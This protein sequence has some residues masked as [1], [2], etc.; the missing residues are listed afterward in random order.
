MSPRPRK[1]T[2]DEVFLAAERAMS[3][4]GPAELTLADIAGEAGVSAGL[5]VQRFGSKKPGKGRKGGEGNR[6][7]KSKERTKS[8]KRK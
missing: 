1:V 5:L 8:R 6:G 4:L 2:D 3:R 7:G